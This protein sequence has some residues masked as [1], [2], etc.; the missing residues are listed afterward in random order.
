MSIHR[1]APGTHTS[2]SLLCNKISAACNGPGEHCKWNNRNGA[3]R[4][5][6]ECNRGQLKFIGRY[7]LAKTQGP[8][9]WKE[10]ESGLLGVQHRSS[11]EA[12]KGLAEKV[13]TDTARSSASGRL[14]H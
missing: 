11:E 4:P 9:S 6:H 14:L 3:H 13:C 12:L 8:G 2:H 1:A 10:V 5:A 7:R